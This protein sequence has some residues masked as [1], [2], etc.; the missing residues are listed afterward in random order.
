MVKYKELRRGNYLL[1]ESEDGNFWQG[2]V[3]DFHKGEKQ[4][5]LY[6]GVQMFYF[7]EDNLRAIPVDEETLLKMNFEKQPNQDGS[8][9]YMKGAFRLQTPKQDGFSQFEIWYKDETRLILNPI[10]LHHLQNHYEDLTKV[11]LTD[12]PI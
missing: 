1:A 9:K 5:G 12:A 8:V 6:N 3:V 10:Y 11:K 7:S 2:T 4:V